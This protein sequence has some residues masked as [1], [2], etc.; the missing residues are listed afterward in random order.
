LHAE[1]D[2]CYILSG[3]T[4]DSAKRGL[5]S[6]HSRRSGRPFL[7]ARDKTLLPALAE[8]HKC[9]AVFETNSSPDET[10]L[11]AR[12]V[13]LKRSPDQ[14]WT[15]DQQRGSIMW[16]FIGSIYRSY[17]RARLLEMRKYHRGA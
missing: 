6:W 17:C 12:E 4:K 16:G 15:A 1:R 7:D 11:A 3:Y 8:G 14:I 9:A 2:D 13:N 5:R 10:I